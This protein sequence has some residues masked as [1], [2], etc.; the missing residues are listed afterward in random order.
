MSVMHAQETPDLFDP[1][2]AVPKAWAILTSAV[3]TGTLQEQLFGVAALAAAGTPRALDLFERVARE[4]PPT[5]RSTA[6]WYLP[7]ENNSKYLP[8]VAEALKHPDLE[9]RRRAIEALGRIR[10]PRTL[11]LL[12]NVIM[13]GDANT[14]EYAVGSARLLGPVAFGV[15]L[16]GIEKGGEGTRGPAIRTIDVLVSP[17]NSS[18]A[19]DNLEALRRLSPERILIKA[20]DDS[21]SLVRVLAALILVR[22]GDETGADELV[23]VLTAD[24]PKFGTIVSRHYA[25]AAL[26]ALGRP[27]YLPALAK[28]LEHAEQRVRLDAALAMRSFPHSAMYDVWNATWRST[29][30]FDVRYWAFQGLIALRGA[31]RELLRAGLVDREPTIRLTAAEQL[32]TLGPDAVAVDTLEGLAAEPRTR[33]RALNLL[34]TNGDPRR[35]GIVARSLLPKSEDLTRISREVNEMDNWLTAIHTLQAVQDREAVPAV[36]ALLGPE[37]NVNLGVVRALVAIGDD[38]ARRTLVRALDSAHSAARIH[39]AGGVISVYAR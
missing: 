16:Q 1:A 31:D 22:L 28:A 34:S 7:I 21:N 25:M 2:V 37:Q 26:H 39:A 12:Q 36:G 10:D 30:P 15:L 3:Q 32:L 20:L 4:G 19:A 6:L 14:I 33:G 38:A 24:D 9:V 17:G 35:T 13:S 5:V 18:T 27:G 29:A 11:P 8:L 23:G